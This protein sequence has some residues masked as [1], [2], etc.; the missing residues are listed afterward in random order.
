MAGIWQLGSVT[1]A[2]VWDMGEEGTYSGVA[3]TSVDSDDT[4]Y[5]GQTSVAIVG[6]E[7][8]ASQGTGGVSIN[9]VVQTITA[10][11]DTQI[12]IA[13]VQGDNKYT[14]HTLTVTTD[15]GVT[16][17]HTVTL[18]ANAPHGFVNLVNP[19]TDDPGSVAYNTSPAAVTGDQFEWN[20][21]NG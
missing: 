16:A 19:I 8:G 18:A 17:D 3:I 20:D 15:I 1:S 10:W 5:P 11:T 2:N 9:G 14:D 12:T 6:T 4:V 7:F 21:A 13:V